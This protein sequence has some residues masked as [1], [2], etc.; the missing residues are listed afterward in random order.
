MSSA[1]PSSKLLEEPSCWTMEGAA[2]SIRGLGSDTDTW[3]LCGQQRADHNGN[4]PHIKPSEKTICVN[5][6][7]FPLGNEQ[8][9]QIVGAFSSHPP[10]PVS[11][12]ME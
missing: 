6:N 11:G 5:N 7:G 1:L 8:E 9:G 12:F 4:E 2:W 3:S 10:P